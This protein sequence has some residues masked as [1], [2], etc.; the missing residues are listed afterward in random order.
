MK[1]RFIITLLLCLVSV[2]TAQ[3][4]Q[5][6]RDDFKAFGIWKGLWLMKD[7]NG[8]LVETWAIKSDTLMESKSYHTKGKVKRLTETV[9]LVYNAGKIQ[10]IAT[11]VGQNDELPVAFDLIGRKGSSFTFENKAHDFPQRI[12]YIL[13]NTNRL[14]VTISGDTPKGFKKTEFNFEKLK[15]KYIS[16]Y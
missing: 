8:S 14:R 11:A 9:Q 16:A 12:I 5:W 4:Q 2:L 7:K 6:T 10:Y 15:G 3:A 13:T 1:N